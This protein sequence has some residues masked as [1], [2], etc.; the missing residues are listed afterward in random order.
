M[1]KNWLRNATNVRSTEKWKSMSSE[2]HSI[3]I[4]TDV[5]QQIGID[6]YGLPEVDGF[7]DLIVCIEYY[8]K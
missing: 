6:I 4:K 7:K 8:S 1:S 5:M 3:S 2:L